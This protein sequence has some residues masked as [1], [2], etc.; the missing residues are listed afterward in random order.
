MSLVRNTHP[1][2]TAERFKL[3]KGETDFHA[4][5]RCMIALTKSK[6]WTLT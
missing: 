2:D 6:I 3:H 1:F 4:R 5:L